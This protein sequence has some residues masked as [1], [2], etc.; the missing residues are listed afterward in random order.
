MRDDHGPPPKPWGE[1]TGAE[2]KAYMRDVVV[3]TLEP[4]FLAYDAER[5]ASF[6]CRTCHGAS[7]R[8]RAYAM[9]SPELFALHPSGTPEQKRLVEEKEEAARFMF[10]A[11]TP[12]MRQLLGAQPYDAATATGFSCFSC[13]PNGQETGET[14]ASGVETDGIEQAAQ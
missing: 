7:A 2:R 3:P 4:L 12:T 14:Q 1:M 8:Q 6:G 5:F 10:N 11:V 13:H 9:P